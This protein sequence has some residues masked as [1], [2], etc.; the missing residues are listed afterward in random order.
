MAGREQ[1]QQPI[2]SVGDAL[3]W[4]KRFSDFSDRAIYRG[5]TRDWPL[6][7]TLLR[8]SSTAVNHGGFKALEDKVLR[9]FKPRAYPYVNVT[10]SSEF[11]WIVLAQHHGSV[12]RLLDWSSNLLVALFFAAEKEDDVDGVVWSIVKFY[13]FS[14]DIDDG[15]LGD[16]DKTGIY[17]PKHLARRTSLAGVTD[18]QQGL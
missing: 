15:A 12:T 1:L 2:N 8:E 14:H 10:P 7:P 17:L 11:D 13:P 16:W 3:S 5:Q 18:W 6:L 9:E 4:T